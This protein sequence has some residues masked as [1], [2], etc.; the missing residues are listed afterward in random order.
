MYVWRCGLDAK[1]S[2]R[3]NSRAS[4]LVKLKFQTQHVWL[5]A[6]VAAN[7][8]K[9]IFSCFFLYAVFYFLEN[10][11]AHCRSQNFL[12]I[13]LNRG[14]QTGHQRLLIFSH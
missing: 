9:K 11:C 7:F 10:I 1:D 3:C 8:Y 6:N 14:S 13:W 2:S 5:I 4:R 12:V